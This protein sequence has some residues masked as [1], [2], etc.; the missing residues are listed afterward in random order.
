MSTGKRGK[1]KKAGQPEKLLLVMLDGHEVPMD[2]I[3]T[4]L[5]SELVVARISTYFWELK[6]IGADIRRNRVGRKIVSY[7]L[8]NPEQ[9]TTYARERGLIAPLPVV[10]TAE[11]L[12]VAAG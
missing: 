3:Q 10:L 7:Q 5:G 8:L 4:L 12:M 9:M 1:N 6:K 11:D 2:E